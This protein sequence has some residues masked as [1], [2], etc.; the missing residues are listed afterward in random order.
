MSCSGVSPSKRAAA[1][2]C[3]VVLVAKPRLPPRTSLPVVRS[4]ILQVLLAMLRFDPLVRNPHLQTILAHYWKRPDATRE[5]P[6]ERRL[7]RTE[8][9]VQ[10]LVL[11]QRPL[12]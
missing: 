11:S 12:G 9:D 5:F 10:V 8:P 4:P 3:W 1:G 6:V 2:D 7:F